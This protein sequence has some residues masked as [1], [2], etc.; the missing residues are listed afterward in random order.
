[1][2]INEVDF[3]RPFDG[4]LKGVFSNFSGVLHGR[5]ADFRRRMYGV[6]AHRAT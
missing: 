3:H 5:S 2:F 1:M 4:I 6:G